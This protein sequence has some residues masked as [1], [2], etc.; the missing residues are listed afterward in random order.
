MNEMPVMKRFFCTSLLAIAALPGVCLATDEIFENHGIIST[1]ISIDAKSVVNHGQFRIDTLIVDG[2]STV[3]YQPYDTS[4]TLYYT[5]YGS[6]IGT[7]GFYFDYVSPQTGL[8]KMAS[9]FINYNPGVVEAVSPIN[10]PLG[11]TSQSLLFPCYFGIIGP[12]KLF[13]SAS[14]IVTGAGFPTAG[15]S[16]IGGA[17]GEMRLTGGNVDLSD[18]GVMINPVW[19]YGIGTAYIVGGDAFIPDISIE[20]LYWAQTNFT[21]AY[22]LGTAGIWNGFT[23]FAPSIPSPPTEPAPFP[24]PS[25]SIGSPI[26]DSYINYLN[27]Y[28]VNVTNVTGNISNVQPGEIVITPVTLASN[29]FKGAIFSAASADFQVDMGFIPSIRPNNFYNNAFMEFSTSVTNVSSGNSDPAV[30]NISDTLAADNFRGVWTNLVNAGCGNLTRRPGNFWIDRRPLGVGNPGNNGYPDPRFYTASGFYLLYPDIIWR[31]QVTNSVVTTGDY[32]G[33]GTYPDSLSFRPP[34]GFL[35]SGLPGTSETNYPGRIYVEA[36]NL[37]LENARLRGDG[38]ITLKATHV[39]STDGTVLD[40]ENV[41]F[42]LNST[43]GALKVENLVPDT[44]S[45]MRGPIYLWSAVWTN[46]VEI[47]LTNYLL[48]NLP[49]FDPPGSTNIVGTN[50]V[51]IFDPITNFCAIGCSATI[52]LAQLSASGYPVSV[53]DG[54]TRS[55]HTEIND[56]LSVVKKFLVEGRSLTVNGTL[57]FPGAIPFEPIIGSV[58]QLE[59]L[60]RWTAATAPNLL[61]LTNHGTISIYSDL[62]LGNDRAVPYAAIVNTGNVSA[63]GI[64][65]RSDY[66]QNNGVL[67]A[68]GALKIGGGTAKLERSV[69][70]SGNVTR[71]DSAAVKFNLAQVTANGALVFNVADSL[72]DSEKTGASQFT[73][74]DGFQMLRRPKSGSLLQSSITSLAPGVPSANLNHTWAATDYGASPAGYQNNL[75]IGNLTL[76]PE[77]NSINPH[78]WFFPSES[79]NAMYVDVLDLSQMPNLTNQLH[80]AQNMVIYYAALRVGFT[81]PPNS[82]GIPRL[83]E[84]YMDGAFNGRLRWVP[85]F[86]GPGSSV[87]VVVSNTPSGPITYLVNRALADS[88]LIDSDGDGIPNGNDGLGNG[89][90]FNISPLALTVVGNGNVSP[91]MNGLPLVIGQKYTFIASANDGAQFVGWSGSIVSSNPQ[92]TFT[93]QSNLMLTATFSYAPVA[94]TYRGLFYEPEAVRFGKSGAVTL[95]TTAS[96]GISGTLQLANAKYS[97]KGQLDSEGAGTFQIPR[98]GDTTL[99]VQLQAGNKFVTGSV[100]DGSWSAALSAGRSVYNARSNPA[101]N[102][103]TYTV[104]LPGNGDPADT[105][106][107]TGD[108]YGSVTISAAGAVKFKG[109]MGDGT[110]VS[111]SSA[112]TDAN[113]WPLYLRLYSGIGQTLGW[114]TVADR[115]I[116]DMGGEISWIK[117]AN[118]TQKFYPDGFDVGFHAAGSTYDSTLA[119]VTG[120]GVGDVEFRGGDTAGFAN[121]VEITSDNKVKNLEANKLSLKLNKSQGLFSGTATDPH[122]GKQIKFNGALFQK[123]DLGR[124]NFPGTDTTGSVLLEP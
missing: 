120:F 61:M 50:L 21:Q 98:N 65:I 45:R 119:P 38:L 11:W 123:L 58:L 42:D 105:S 104:I 106:T 111:L 43:N 59:P 10:A 51:A 64:S 47:V 80:I 67:A 108:G 49:V 87:P 103:G 69:T 30:I 114:M 66:L 22:P 101:P 124:G 97:F 121:R 9:S 99:T 7:N 41:S 110:K 78:W 46:Q 4:G 35:G 53:F 31:D 6:M 33:Y 20:D 95:S 57:R 118:A 19:N 89:D 63:A 122:S 92:L 86:A 8:R 107:P 55:R 60:Q 82:N 40:C 79:R 37:N 12:S 81:P 18:S 34:V 56:N 76:A 94:A 84:E 116:E 27:I 100:G 14:N 71:F 93:M 15:A 25:I 29:E 3:H 102:T 117:Q 90:K 54:V 32:S 96:R 2:P 91:D 73:L 85:T 74:R 16:I 68:G 72:T 13:I 70:T 36:A 17:S 83:P 48:T 62:N 23:A 1:P 24:S 39:V 5:N 26:S 28:V 115:G 113:Q 88:L 75:A 112:L 77:F 109:A 52:G 44:V